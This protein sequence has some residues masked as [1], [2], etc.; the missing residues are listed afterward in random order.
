MASVDFK[1][2]AA[3]TTKFKWMQTFSS[4]ETPIFYWQNI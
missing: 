4:I 2:N 3:V 1:Y